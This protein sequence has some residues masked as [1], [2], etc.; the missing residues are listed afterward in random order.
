MFISN[1]NSLPSMY[2]TFGII[3][4]NESKM[5]M[6]VDSGATIYTSNKGYNQW[7]VLRCP[8]MITEYLDRGTDTEYNIVQLLTA[9]TLRGTH[10]PIYH[11]N[12]TAVI[13]YKNTLFYQLNL[14]PYSFF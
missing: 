11:G 14:T 8:S 9:L 7:V 13:R 12:M 1:D 3:A 5:R 4:D 2:L 6:I 10:Q